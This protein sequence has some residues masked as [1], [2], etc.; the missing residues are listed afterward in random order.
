MCCQTPATDTPASCDGELLEELFQCGLLQ[1]YMED[2]IKDGYWPLLL[3]TRANSFD[4]VKELIKLGADVNHTN[5][6][7]TGIVKATIQLS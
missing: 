1:K 2:E 3:A 4:I 6:K 5:E 7:G